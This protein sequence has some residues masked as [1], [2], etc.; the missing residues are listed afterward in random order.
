M[1][2]H[3]VEPEKLEIMFISTHRP[4]D[5]QGPT[6][7]PALQFRMVATAACFRSQHTTKT[8]S[9]IDLHQVTR[10]RVG[11]RRAKGARPTASLR[12]AN[13]KPGQGSEAG[14][15]RIQP[16]PRGH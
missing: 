11:S 4:P 14:A 10:A 6:C 15:A 12:Q 1:G 3:S 2:A 7:F 8:E 16:A 9:G 5:G 13:Q